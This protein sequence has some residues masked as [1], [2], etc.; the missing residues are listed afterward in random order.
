MHTTSCK[1][2]HDY[3]NKDRFNMSL[4]QEKITNQIGK[5]NYEKTKKDMEAYW[6]LPV[7]NLRTYFEMIDARTAELYHKFQGPNSEGDNL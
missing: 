3:I 5:E 4:L 7:K 2:V 6:K 1:R